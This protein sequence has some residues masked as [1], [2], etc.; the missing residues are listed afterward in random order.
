MVQE[1]NTNGFIITEDTYI[2][3]GMM[4]NAL[5]QH[6]HGA[7]RAN[8]WWDKERNVGELLCLIHSEISEA[9][10]GHRKD[11]MD[12]HIPEQLSITVELSDAL[13]RIFDLAGGLNLNIGEA[14]AEKFCY[15]QIRTD[16]KI[17]NRQAPG[18]KKF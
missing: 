6:C 5:T 1:T 12:E 17:A 8:N 10:E 16:H 7:A 9:M 13:I 2:K 4:I 18:G 11:K 3:M 15:N 14:F